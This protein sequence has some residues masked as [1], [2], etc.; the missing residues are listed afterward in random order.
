[1]REERPLYYNDQYDFCALS[2]FDDV[3]RCLVDWGTY[4]SAG[5]RCSS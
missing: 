4:S 2:R 1:M 3:E 5:A